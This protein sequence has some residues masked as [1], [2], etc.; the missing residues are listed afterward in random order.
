MGGFFGVVST[1]DAISDVFFGTDYHSHLGPRRGGMAAYDAEIGLQRDIH[2]IENSPFRTKFDHI[3]EEMKGN[4]AIGCI[5]D[6]DPQPLLMRSSMGVYAISFVGRINNAEELIDKYL[7]QNGGHFNAMTGG[8][9]NSVELVSALISYKGDFCEGIKF[10]QDNIDGST[11]IL[12]LKGDG[13]LIAARDKMGRLPVIIGK[14]Q[15]GHSVSFESFAFE[16]LDYKKEYELLDEKYN[17]LSG[18]RAE[19]AYELAQLKAS[20]GQIR[21][22]DAQVRELHENVRRLKHDMKNHIMVIASYLNGGDYDKAK[23]YTSVILDKLNAV[24][25]YIET[26]NALLITENKKREGI[27]EL[28]HRS[29]PFL[30]PS[31]IRSA[32]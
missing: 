25:S 22:Q 29:I 1:H 30:T 32:Q 7:L 26:G 8:K 2:N 16:K 11:S 27:T 24:H 10:A 4:S 23:E 13:N 5:S 20:M 6:S 21:E 14:S 9:I 12:I 31:P 15:Y 28:I 3:F 19:L 18:E 17:V